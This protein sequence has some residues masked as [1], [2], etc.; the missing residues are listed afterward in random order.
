MSHKLIVIPDHA[1]AEYCF[2]TTD[3]S[4]LMLATCYIAMAL[5]GIGFAAGIFGAEGTQAIWLVVFLASCISASCIYLLL[6]W[7]EIVEGRRINVQPSSHL[8]NYLSVA[9]IHFS[10]LTAGLSLYWLSAITPV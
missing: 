4:I 5:T 8:H 6:A 9:Y 1:V 3:R 10:I 2:K 7:H